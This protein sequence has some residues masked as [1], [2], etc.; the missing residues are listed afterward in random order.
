MTR[1]LKQIICK[2]VAHLILESLFARLQLAHCCLQV[3]FG[4]ILIL[5]TADNVALTERMRVLLSCAL[6]QNCNYI[7]RMLTSKGWGVR[8]ESCR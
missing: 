6:L 5:K 4:G 1:R 7:K 8:G 3:I 2:N